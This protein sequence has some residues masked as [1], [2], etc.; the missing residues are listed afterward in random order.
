MIFSYLLRPK[1]EKLY[2]QNENREIPKFRQLSPEMAPA[3]AASN[4]FNGGWYRFSV[5]IKSDYTLKTWFKHLGKKSMFWH[6][7]PN[8]YYGLEAIISSH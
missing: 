4:E 5:S 7:F 8:L 6:I 3:D 1:H 2:S